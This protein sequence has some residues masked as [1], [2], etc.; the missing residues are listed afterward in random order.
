MDEI[1]NADEAI[2]K[3]LKKADENNNFECL[4]ELVHD[5]FSKL[6]SETNNNGIESQITFLVTQ[7]G[8]KAEKLIHNALKKD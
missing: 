6:A 4:D 5:T 3:L 2:Q 8:P 7:Y 1:F